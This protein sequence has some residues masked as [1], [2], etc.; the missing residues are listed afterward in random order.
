[1]CSLR[2]ALVVSLSSTMTSQAGNPLV[3]AP[4][5]EAAYSALAN[6][7][8]N[9]SFEMDWM[10]NRVTVNTSF[11]LL[12]QSDWGYAQSDGRPDYWVVPDSARLD[13]RVAKFGKASLRLQGTASQVIYLL[14]ETDPK[15]G[16]AYYNAFRPLPGPMVQHVKPR[17]LRFGAGARRRTRA[18]RP[19]LTVVMEYGDGV[20]RTHT[21]PLRREPMTGNISRWSFRPPRTCRLRTP[22]CYA[23]RFRARDRPGSTACWERRPRRDEINL[24][25]NGDFETLDKRLAGGWSAPE[26]WT[27]SRAS[28]TA[29]RDGPIKRGTFPKKLEIRKS[30]S[31][32]VWSSPWAKRRPFAAI[33]AASR[34]QFRR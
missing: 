9:P 29:S 26:L 20:T 3:P 12:E 27:W 7:V 21:W 30:Q 1:M 24:L 32:V 34:R 2:I 15:D 23:F 25:A 31:E 19:A 14:G 11:L 16:G 28:I 13:T 8:S 6:L 4:S 18:C 10:H 17:P 22:R 33:H 5:T